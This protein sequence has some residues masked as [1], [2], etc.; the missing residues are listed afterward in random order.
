MSLEKFKKFI[1]VDTLCSKVWYSCGIHPLYCSNDNSILELEK[2]ANNRKVIAIGETGLDY[3]HHRKNVN[4]QKKFFRQHI[5]TALKLNKPLI[6]H[7]RNSSSDVL[8]ILK[9]EKAHICKGVIHSFTES[10]S[11]AKKFL[12]MNFFISFSGITTFK[13]AQHLLE[14]VKFIPIERMLIETDSP[15]LTPVP[16]RG[17]ENQP[18]YLYNIANYLSKIK[19]MNLNIFSAITTKNFYRLFFKH[20][21]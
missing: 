2:F 5:R 6:V 17:R 8:K 1:L 7:T 4:L 13:N 12:D 14:V 19:N 21:K 20:N 10:K 11:I 16:Y 9:E 15:Y 3:Y 18:A